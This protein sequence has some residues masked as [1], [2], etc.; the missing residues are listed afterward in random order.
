MRGVEVLTSP[1]V[2]NN[3]RIFASFILILVLFAPRFAHCQEQPDLDA[4]ASKAAAEIRKAAESG[5]ATILVIDFADAHAKPNGLGALLADQFADLLRKNTQGLIVIDRADYARATAEDV[6]TPEARADE[7]A[8]RCYCRQLGAD[9]TVEGTIDASSDAVQLNVKVTRLGDRKSV[10]GGAASLPLTPE[11]RANLSKPATTAPVSRQGDKNTWAN[12]DARPGVDITITPRTQ[13]R[14]KPNPSEC[15]YCPNAQ[16][17]D[18]AVKAK[19][20][21]TILL[22]LIID[23][24]GRPASISVMRGLPCSLSSQAIESV[25]KWRFKPALDSN[26]NPIPARQVVEIT[27]HLY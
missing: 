3:S 12:P 21:G 8:A 9:F 16:F 17:S 11:L 5:D 26:E 6:L 14:T 20:Q 4:L 23:A 10:F 15:T 24:A 13:G 25:K 18:A 7:Q 22:A 27:F 2:R 19:A 1:V